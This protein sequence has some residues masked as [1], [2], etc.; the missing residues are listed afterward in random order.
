MIYDYTKGMIEKAS[1]D[2]DRFV[3]ELKKANRVLLPEEIEKLSHWLLYF[4]EGK[5]ELRELI[6]M[7]FINPNTHNSQEEH[8]C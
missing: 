1:G 5:P 6:L 7:I 4:S 8:H 2:K 3:K